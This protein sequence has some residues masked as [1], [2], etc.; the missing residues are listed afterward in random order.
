MS[1]LLGC[2]F[3]R[4]VTAYIC[5]YVGVAEN[6]IPDGILHLIGL[7]GW[8]T[9]PQLAS[10]FFCGEYMA[11]QTQLDTCLAIKIPGPFPRRLK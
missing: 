1:T 2:R 8:L 4:P 7:A 10:A 6:V 9:A 11:T 3:K 5:T